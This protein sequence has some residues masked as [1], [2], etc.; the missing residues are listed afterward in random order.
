MIPVRKYRSKARVLPWDP[1]NY[2]AEV[3]DLMVNSNGRLYR[4]AESRGRNKAAAG[5]LTPV[6][7]KP[8]SP[9]LYAKIIDG[10]VWWVK[11]K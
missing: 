7:I 9:E 2:S 6:L 3:G 5:E 1:W 8:P 4:L 10:E 11:D